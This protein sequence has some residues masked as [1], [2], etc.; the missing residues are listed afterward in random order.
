MGLFTPKISQRE[1]P[2]VGV[3]LR[4]IDDCVLL[5]NSTVKPDVFFGRLNF[6][7][8]LLLRLRPYERCH[9]FKKSTP[10]A[11]YRRVLANLE[12]TVDDF[13]DRAQADCLARISALKTEKAQKSRSEKFAIALIS[14]FDC[15]H[16]FWAGDRGFPHYDGPLY[17]EKNLRRVKAIYDSLEITL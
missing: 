15:S 16:S 17:T 1:L 7:L 12:S 13:I 5:V 8:D 10:T 9:I 11:D 2:T 4:Q 3:S 14:A 6:L